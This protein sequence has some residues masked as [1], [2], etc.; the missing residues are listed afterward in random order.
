MRCPHQC[1]LVAPLLAE[2][3]CQVKLVRSQLGTHPLVG[4]AFAG[5][6]DAH[7]PDTLNLTDHSLRP[8]L[9][10]NSA[11]LLCVVHT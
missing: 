5:S 7:L 3:P 2:V 1:L 4:P 8:S 11:V 10:E 6:L 9:D